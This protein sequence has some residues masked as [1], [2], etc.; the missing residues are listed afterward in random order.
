MCTALYWKKKIGC[1]RDDRWYCP[2]AEK[3]GQAVAEGVGGTAR[4]REKQ[5]RQ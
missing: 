4:W 1:S 5:A 3:A 2:E